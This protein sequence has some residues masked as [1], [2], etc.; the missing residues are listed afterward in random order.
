MHLARENGQLKYKAAQEIS[1]IEQKLSKAM[2]DKSRLEKEL[3][4]LKETHSA[5][6]HDNEGQVKYQKLY[7][8]LEAKFEDLQTSLDVKTQLLED[9]NDTID[10]LKQ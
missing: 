8:Q 7:E 4:D 6:V 5:L 9:K 10:S 2:Y 1:S 3:M